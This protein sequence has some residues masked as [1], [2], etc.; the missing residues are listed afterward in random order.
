MTFD[1]AMRTRLPPN[2]TSETNRHGTRVFYYRVGKGPRTRLPTYGTPEF[3]AAYRAALAGTPLPAPGARRALTTGTLAWALAEYQQSLH[4]RG[5]DPVTRR[6]RASIFQQLVDKS[7]QRLL[8]DIRDTDIIDARE[9]R[10]TG[11]GHAA[12]IFLR[13]VKPFFA[14]CTERGWLVTDPAKH[15]DRV[16]TAKGGRL[17]WNMDDVAK[18]EARHPLGTMANL[19]MRILLFTG[20]RRSDAVILGRQHI[21]DGV[22]RFRPGKTA[23]SSGVTVSFTA[24]PPLLEA[25]AATKTG[26]LTFLMTEWG[27]PFSDGNSFGNWFRDRCG[28]AKVPGRAHG[29]RKLG[30]AL[31]A[32][33]GATAN[34]L[35]AM[36]G[37]TT[38]AQAE[39]YTR[40]ANRETLGVTAS[41]K[42]LAGWTEMVQKAN[43]IPRTSDQGAGTEQKT[44]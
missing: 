37:W 36:W 1:A 11:K 32:E 34:E 15:V 17:A 40:S 26:D 31:A 41:A 21:R 16:K 44:K 20:L 19:A 25:I 23:G 3:E 18:F 14:Y 35:M 38:L 4:F 5:L 12:N 43:N 42:L 33:W 29:L 9:K 24:L 28:E 7:G 13:A 10:T 2:V 39:L 22:V 27:R 8:I 6:R 30:P